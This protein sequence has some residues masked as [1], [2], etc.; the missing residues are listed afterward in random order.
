MHPLGSGGYQPLSAGYSGL[1]SQQSPSDQAG[2]PVQDPSNGGA[3]DAAAAAAAAAAATP[4]QNGSGAAPQYSDINQILDQIL[5][6]T[7]QSLDEAQVRIRSKI[8]SKSQFTSKD[9]ATGYHCLHLQQNL[10]LL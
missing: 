5:N 8:I 9:K 10:W 3:G 6:I 1:D 2:S 4:G 7:D